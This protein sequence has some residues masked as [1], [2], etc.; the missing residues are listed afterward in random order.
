MTATGKR[1]LSGLLLLDKPAGYSSNHALQKVKR[2][3]RAEKAGHTGTL[4]L[5]VDGRSALD[6]LPSRRQ[7]KIMGKFR[8][9]F[10]RLDLKGAKCV[11]GYFLRSIFYFVVGQRTRIRL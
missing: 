2:L 8:D 10:E 4:L 5:V 6:K 3:F 11:V 1:A 9:A 7:L